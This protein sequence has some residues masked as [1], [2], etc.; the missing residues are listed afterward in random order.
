MASV[1]Q[2]AHLPALEHNGREEAGRELQATLVELV[3]LS[4]IGRQLHWNIFGQLFK[5]LHEHLDELVYSWRDL[6]DTVAERAVALGVAARFRAPRQRSLWSTNWTWTTTNPST[7][8]APICSGGSAETARPQRP[9]SAQPRWR[10]PTPSGTSSGS[11][12]ERR[13]ELA[14]ALDRPA[15]NIHRLVSTGGRVEPPEE[16]LSIVEVH[17]PAVTVKSID[18]ME[19]IYGG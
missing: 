14:A 8:P 19:A 15:L 2:E 3:D 13:A 12:A 16:S 4:L 7:P 17:M 11:V 9:T 18:D 1:A 6:A 10:Q 5:P